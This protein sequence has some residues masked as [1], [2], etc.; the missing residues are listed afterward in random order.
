M[1]DPSSPI[2]SPG[3]ATVEDAFK[4]ASDHLMD[5]NIPWGS[6]ILNL[7]TRG[8]HPG[9]LAVAAGFPHMGKTAFCVDTALQAARA[10][11]TVAYLSFDSALSY[12]GLRLFCALTGWDLHRLEGGWL[13]RRQSDYVRKEMLIE[14]GL[15]IYLDDRTLTDLRAIRE[16]TEALKG[17]K[18][19]DLLIL[20]SLRPLF[21]RLGSAGLTTE[22]LKEQVILPLKELAMDRQCQVLATLPLGWERGAKMGPGLLATVDAIHEMNLPE[23]HLDLL[24]ALH[25]NREHEY[26]SKRSEVEVAVL[27]NRHGRTYWYTIGFDRDSL[28]LNG[29]EESWEADESR[30]PAKIRR[31]FPERNMEPDDETE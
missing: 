7:L 31:P 18:G 4:Q 20:D 9:D 27:K 12:I 2:G 8:S 17:D 11:K 19:L 16:T 23:L 6:S 25:L 21:P 14:T 1:K 3:F 5:V 30:E 26:S 22:D 13:D 15:P 28:S 24:I 10:G 29:F